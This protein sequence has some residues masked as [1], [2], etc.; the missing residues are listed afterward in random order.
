MQGN[1]RAIDATGRRENWRKLIRGQR[2]LRAMYE[3]HDLDPVGRIPVY[4]VEVTEPGIK[5]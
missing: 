5:P 2:V 1:I 4:H 3:R